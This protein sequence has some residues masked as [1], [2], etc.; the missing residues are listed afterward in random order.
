MAVGSVKSGYSFLDTF[1]GRFFNTVD[2][3]GPTSY[4]GGVGAGDLLSP[5]AFGFNNTIQFVWASGDQ[6][7]LLIGIPF[8]V[9]NG[10]TK[11]YLRWFA[12]SAT[13]PG[14][15][16][17]VTNGTNLSTKILKLTAVGF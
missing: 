11:W 8:P 13:T 12:V 7:G 2:Y 9:N 4:V 3:S 17:E 16:A 10:V 15:G 6:T 5:N 14:I 1:G